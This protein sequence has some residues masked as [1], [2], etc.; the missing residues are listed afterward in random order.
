MKPGDLI[1]VRGKPNLIDDTIKVFES[2]ETHQPPAACYTHVAIFMGNGMIAEAQGGRRTGTAPLSQYDGNYDVVTMNLTD[3]ERGKVVM[4]AERQFG[5]EY[6]WFE[7]G[8]LGV[9]I[10]TGVDIPYHERNARICTTY[11]KS[12][13][14]NALGRHLCDG[15]TPED[16]WLSLKKAA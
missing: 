10:L 9:E 7:I 14:L 3:E 15:D 11:V 2:I 12:V 16:L 5:K 1:F 6:D 8:V 13:F 4:E